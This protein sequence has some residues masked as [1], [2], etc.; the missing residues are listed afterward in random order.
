MVVLHVVRGKS[1]H[2]VDQGRLLDDVHL[3]I[4]SCAGAVWQQ[5]RDYLGKTR[6]DSPWIINQLR[7]FRGIKSK[8][9]GEINSSHSLQKVELTSGN[10]TTQKH[11]SLI[12]EHFEINNHLYAI[13]QQAM[14]DFQRLYPLVIVYITMENRHAIPF[15]M[16]KS[17][18][19]MCHFQ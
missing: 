9:I 1:L 11:I 12:N 7:F 14:F 5:W 16:G 19:S 13:F 3:G 17:I 10:Q 18:I 2:P 15:S 8:K 4:R 6:K